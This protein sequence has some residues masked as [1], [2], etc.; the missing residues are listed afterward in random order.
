MGWGTSSRTIIVDSSRPFK[1][2]KL[3]ARKRESDLLQID[4]KSF[5][6]AACCT[7]NFF[8]KKY[9]SNLVNDEHPVGF[10]VSLLG[11]EGPQQV[12]RGAKVAHE[13]FL[14]KEIN[15][16]FHTFVSGNL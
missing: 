7:Y 1:I 9:D 12:E 11:L 16:R 10:P 3:L 2:P 5:N 6:L 8:Y 14:K 4:V 13:A 15:L